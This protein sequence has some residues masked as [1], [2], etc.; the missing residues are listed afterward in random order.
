MHIVLAQE[1]WTET[2]GD[3]KH[4]LLITFRAAT[5]MRCAR[6]PMETANWQTTNK[7]EINCHALTTFAPH[8]DHAYRQGNA[9]HFHPYLM[10]L[11]QLWRLAS[12]SNGSVL[13]HILHSKIISMALKS[14]DTYVAYINFTMVQVSNQNTLIT[15]FPHVLLFP[16]LSQLGN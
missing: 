11:G 4:L 14:S 12:T 7:T 9:W 1:V 16:F 15:R 10:R 5:L 6:P 8:W 13:L 3:Q 2:L